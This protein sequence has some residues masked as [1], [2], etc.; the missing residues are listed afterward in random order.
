MNSSQIEDLNTPEPGWERMVDPL[1]AIGADPAF[2]TGDPEGRRIRIR[3]FRRP[4]D[5]R[6][7]GKVWFGPGCEGPPGHAHGGSIAAAMDEA[8]GAAAWAEGHSVVAARLQI[9]Y[10]NMTPLERVLVFEA[11]IEAVEGR[12]VTCRGALKDRDGRVICESDGL[13]LTIGMDRFKELVE[14]KE[15]A[16]K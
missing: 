15:A 11:W 12:K 3:Y 14:K 4:A 10:R 13:F 1:R 16:A 7:V 8:M 9:H 6:L 5:R 2:V